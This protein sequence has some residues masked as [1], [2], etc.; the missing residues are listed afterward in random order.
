[1]KNCW[2]GISNGINLVV[3]QFDVQRLPGDV[4]GFGCMII[5]I[6]FLSVSVTVICSAL[7]NVF[8]IFFPS[9]LSVFFISISHA[10]R[11]GV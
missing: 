9:L 6:I 10:L 7:R 2:M 5:L 1:M 3:V 4:W 11:T 8:N